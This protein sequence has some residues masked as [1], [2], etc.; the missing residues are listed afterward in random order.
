MAR[1]ATPSKN[2]FVIPD[3]L[4]VVGETDGSVVEGSRAARATPGGN[5]ADFEGVERGSAVL[6]VF[7]CVLFVA[8]VTAISHSLAAS[9]VAAVSIAGGVAVVLVI[10]RPS[11]C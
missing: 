11:C 4:V 3:A 7:T 1:H 10:L 6:A 8:C 9:V 5:G 2:T